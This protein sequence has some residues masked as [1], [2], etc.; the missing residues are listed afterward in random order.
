MTGEIPLFEINP[1]LQR[2]RLAETFARDRRVQ[3]RDLLTEPAARTIHRVLSRET[4]W[5]LAWRAGD[6]GPNSL[7]RHEIAQRQ[8]ELPAITGK[9][10]QAMRGRDYAFAY[11]HYPILTAYQE[12]WG[13]HEALRLLME[14]INDEPLMNLVREITGIESL[15]KADAQATLYGPNH[16]LAAHDDSHVA[17]GWQVAYVMHFCAEDWRP[18][19]GGYLLFY[20]EAGDVVAGF[21]PRFNALNLFRVPQRHSV[22][23]VPSFA[24]VGRFAITGWF[25]DR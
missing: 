24:P 3:V 20:D 17:E 6:D 14:H 10:S 25:R 16:F 19:W 13:E 21:R 22:S 1:G 12:D 9:I 5:G 11:A 15:V 8:A 23:Y 18:D 2:A 7:R 4:P